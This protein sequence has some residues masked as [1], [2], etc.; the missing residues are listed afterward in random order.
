MI[1]YR[2]ADSR[3]PIFDATG[4]M[5]HGGRWN[6]VGVRAI[7]AAETYAGALLEVLVHANL[8]QPP[9]HHRVVRI[10]IPEKTKVETVSA[11]DVSGWD[12]EDMAASRGFGDR[13]VRENRTAVLRVPSLVTL[14]R[15][16][17]IVF[18]PLHPQFAVIRAE[19]PEPV[20]WDARLFR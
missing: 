14:G 18:N 15:E 3:H 13:W 20:H 7:Y 8:S 19:D 11:A 16:N 4:A 12:A 9:K 10:H 6:S 5:L 2:I 17:N 1:A